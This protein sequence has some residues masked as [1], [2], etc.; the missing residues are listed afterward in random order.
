MYEINIFGFFFFIVFFKNDCLFS[1]KISPAVHHVDTSLLI[2]PAFFA[3]ESLDKMVGDLH[4]HRPVLFVLPFLSTLS[5]LPP[6]S[7]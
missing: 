7:C 6:S 5:F 2:T 3:A 1:F 4:C